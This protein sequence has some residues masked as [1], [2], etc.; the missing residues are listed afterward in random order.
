MSIIETEGSATVYAEP[1]RA[2]FWLHLAVTGESLAAAMADAEAYE[3]QVRAALEAAQLA[4][5]EM[6]ISAPAVTSVAEKQIRISAQL[7]FNL[8]NYANPDTGRQEFAVLCDNLAAVAT[9]L[10]ATIAGPQLEL[11]DEDMLIRT[12]AA[13]ATEDAYPAAEAIA[14]ALK[15][16]IFA[17][18]TVSLSEVVWNQTPETQAPLPNFKAISCTVRVRVIYALAGE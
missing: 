17:V 15:S 16:T 11:R 13:Q 14:T 7:A 12:A 9:Q 2:E 3:E 6:T 8:S 10:E 5:S 4:P 18:E 1:T